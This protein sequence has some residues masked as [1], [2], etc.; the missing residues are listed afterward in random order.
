MEQNP[1]ENG[2]DARSAMQ[3]KCPGC[4][5]V[6]VYS[7]K[8]RGLKCVYCGAT[9]ELPTTRVEV[10]EN[11]YALWSQTSRS[12]RM[13]GIMGSAETGQQEDGQ[14]EA[15]LVKCEQCGATVQIDTTRSS[16]IC[17]YCGTPLMLEK[18]QV[19]RF[20]QPNYL[21]PFAIDRKQCS[22]LFQKWLDGKWFL[23]SKYKKGNVLEEKFQG[24]YYPYWAY[25]AHTSTDYNGER[26][27]DRTVTKK[28]SDG[29]SVKETVTDWKRV[30]GNIVRDFKNILVP[31]SKSLPKDVIDD[32][33]K[34]PVGEVVEY[35]PEY[36]AG[37]STEVYTVDFTE[38]M[39]SAKNQME[40]QIESD[41]RN[42][43]GGDRQRISHKQVD[44]SDLV[45]KLI[46]LPLWV[47]AFTINDKTYQFIIN[48]RTGE[49]HGDYPMDKKKITLVVIAV[50]VVVAL[51][52]YVLK[53][54]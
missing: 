28:G 35:T 36:T 49:V 25:G 14:Q 10:K 5:G 45:F 13:F 50:I 47:S 46:L 33:K 54:L 31:A 22:E 9:K 38:G 3:I 12:D 40:D 37:F 19:K 15:T 8:T 53:M 1:H 24:V 42:D 2:R 6:M 39:I 11:D 23:P 26:G 7:P 30:S 20:W 41:I 52:Y 27:T 21:L 48:G 16:A 43:I 29:K 51:L 44:Y 34:W 4:G 18:S 17:P 32:H